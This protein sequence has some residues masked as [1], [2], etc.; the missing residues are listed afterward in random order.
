MESIVACTVQVTKFCICN[1]VHS[2][3]C[4]TY[5]SLIMCF[6]KFVFLCC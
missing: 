5:S 4:W 1:T 3:T 6:Q 2:T